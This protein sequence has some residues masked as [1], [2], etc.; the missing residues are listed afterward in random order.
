MDLPYCW[1]CARVCSSYDQHH[2]VPSHL[3][4]SE[5][6]TV[7]LCGDCHTTLHTYATQMYAKR[8]TLD[9]NLYAPRHRMRLDY[10]ADVIV[11]AMIQV[12]GVGGKNWVYSRKW[13]DVQ[14]AQL[15]RLAHIYGSQDKAID[16][17]LTKL[18]DMHCYGNGR[19]VPR[20]KT[21]G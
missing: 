21:G 5:G 12:E 10:L 1:V 17:A 18:Y 3:G 20:I 2:V 7:T 11:R 13:S 9:L 16:A 4:G 8:V 19:N 15:V 14:H 6:P